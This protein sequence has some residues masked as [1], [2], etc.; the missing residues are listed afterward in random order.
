MAWVGRAEWPLGAD[1]FVDPFV[2]D[3]C[4]VR[5]FTIAIELI[6]ADSCPGRAGVLLAVRR[7]RFHNVEKI[8]ELA[9][10]PRPRIVLI[11]NRIDTKLGDQSIERDCVKRRTR[12]YQ[13]LCQCI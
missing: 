1:V 4:E 3:G 11:G 5:S 7:R 6:A 12:M 8:W 10:Q 13:C 9:P 2:A